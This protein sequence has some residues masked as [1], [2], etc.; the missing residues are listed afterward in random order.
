MSA[1]ILVDGE[2][3]D[4]TRYEGYKKAAQAAV[5][6]YGGRYLVRGGAAQV[7]EGDWQP[8]R[9]VVLEFPSRES[10]RR[11]FTSPEY[12]AARKLRAGAARMNIIAVD[13][14]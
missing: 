4:P 12:Q 9:I 14:A 7:L 2:V 6:L 11:F 13:G 10:V 8:H 1:Y 5:E 3:T